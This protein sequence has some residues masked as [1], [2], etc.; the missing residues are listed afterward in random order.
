MKAPGGCLLTV[1]VEA[2][3]PPPRS[4]EASVGAEAEG[5]LLALRSH[6]GTWLV[7]SLGRPAY[8]WKGAHI[9]GFADCK[10]SVVQDSAVAQG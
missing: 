10:V 7:L 8:F 9:L 2:A 4:V 5:F 3:P 1:S 6:C